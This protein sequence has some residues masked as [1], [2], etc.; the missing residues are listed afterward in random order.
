MKKDEDERIVKEKR[1]INSYAFN[2]L[3]I[4]LWIILV[5]RQFVLGQSIDQYWDIFVLTLGGSFFV[6]INNMLKGIYL[7][8]KKKDEKYKKLLVSAAIGTIIFITVNSIFSG[9]GFSNSEEIISTIIS[10]VVFFIVWIALQAF[11]IHIS[12]KKSKQEIEE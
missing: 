3:F 10:A 11:I 2:I 9:N 1:K 4:G 5:Y 8:Y 7:T 6:L 12:E